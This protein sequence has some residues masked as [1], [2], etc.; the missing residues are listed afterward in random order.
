MFFS[1]EV[2]S[3]LAIYKYEI[4]DFSLVDVLFGKF[5]IDEDLIVIKQILLLAN[6]IS[7]G[8]IS[9]IQKFSSV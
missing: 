9:T 7:R 5:D 1:K 8:V 6:F 3:W 2:L 4:V